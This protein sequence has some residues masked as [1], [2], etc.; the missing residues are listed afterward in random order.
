MKNIFILFVIFF[1]INS[2]ADKADDEHTRIGKENAEKQRAAKEQYQKDHPDY[3]MSEGYLKFQIQQE[4]EDY[5]QQKTKL[6]FLCTTYK[7]FCFDDASKNADIR[8]RD[9]NISQLTH[10]FDLSKKVN[11]KTI[12]A[13][14]RDRQHDSFLLD[15]YKNECEVFKRLCD[16]FAE[17]KL[18][19]KNKYNAE[20]GVATNIPA[21]VATGTAAVAATP[22]ATPTVAKIAIAQTGGFKTETCKWVSDMPRRLIFGPG[23]DGGRNAMLCTGYV[24]CEAS[25][26]GKFIRQSTCGS[27]NC[28]EGSAVACTKQAS[29]GSCKP[30]TETR[31]GISE[32]TTEA[33]T[34]ED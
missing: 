28:G 18:E 4:E 24:V 12:T 11:A 2:F 19:Y 21:P 29:Y 9:F 5:Q 8:D 10:D 6:E 32:R 23:C 17:R 22:V 1:S 7:R 31:T 25:A 20:Y 26:G 27:A 14:E 16:I 30:E 13:K 34:I 15:R 33:L 3:A